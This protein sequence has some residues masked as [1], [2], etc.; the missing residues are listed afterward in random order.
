[1]P[2]DN[3]WKEG[4]DPSPGFDTTSYL[5][6]NPDLKA[7]GIDPLLHYLAAGRHEGRSALGDGLWG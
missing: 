2:P 7:A 5:D 1:M 4:R 3:C 6:D